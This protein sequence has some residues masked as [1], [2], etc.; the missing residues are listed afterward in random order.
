[1]LSHREE[2]ILPFKKTQL[3][4][5]VLDVEKY[6]QFLPWCNDCKIIKVEA[7]DHFFANLKIEYNKICFSYISEI[8]KLEKDNK[9]IIDVTSRKGPFRKLKNIWEFEDSK[10]GCKTDF[11]ISIQLKSTILNK[12]LKLIY[13]KAYEKMLESFTNR[14]HKIYKS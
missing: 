3:A 14:A 8:K 11:F 7:K 13:N 1:M 9:I 2:K 10:D 5:L 6:P 12:L 4:D